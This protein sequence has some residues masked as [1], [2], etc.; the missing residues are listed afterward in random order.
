M[1]YWNPRPLASPSIMVSMNA[2]LIRSI[3]FLQSLYLKSVSLPPTMAFISAMSSGTVQ[4]RVM[5]EKGAWVPSGWGC[6]LHR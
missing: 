3:S 2:L 6:S 5:L 4:S 1:G